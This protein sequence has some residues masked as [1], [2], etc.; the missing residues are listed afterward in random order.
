M[1]KNKMMRTAAVL[2][3][4][5]MLTASVLSGTFAKYTT[6]AEGTDSARVAKWGLND[7]SSITLTNLFKDTYSNN[8]NVET[9][10]SGETS[11]DV[12]APGTSGSATFKF[13]YTGTNGKDNNSSTINAPEVGYTF[14][15]DTTGSTCDAS[16]K[17][18]PNIV[19]SLDGEECKP[20]ENETDKYSWDVLLEKIQALDGNVGKNTDNN[21]PANYYAPGNLPDAFY[22]TTTDG[23]ETVKANAEHTVSW[24]WD[25]ESKTGD[26]ADTTQDSKDTAIDGTWISRDTVLF[27]IGQY[28]SVTPNPSG[29]YSF[30]G[31]KNGTYQ[32]SWSLVYGEDATDNI[33]G[34]TIS[35]TASSEYT[36][37]HADPY[38]EVTT[39]ADTRVLTAGTETTFTFDCKAASA[40][41]YVTVEKQGNLCT[42]SKVDTTNQNSTVKIDTAANNQAKVTFGKTTEAGTYRI[43]F[44]TDTKSR[45]DNVYFTFIIK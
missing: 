39:N 31:L 45:N 16:I 28:G 4:A 23:K 14:V 43:C 8:N 37:D 34:N 33:A 29:E 21:T 40:N 30:T 24:K 27:A 1:R 3:V 13:E 12:I 36:E 9:V 20:T 2:G 7:T 42:F 10:K 11:Q 18:N 22:K 44:S 41:V 38:L 35:N 19:W 6:T 17:Q 5:T 32:I 15:V 26:T 25:F